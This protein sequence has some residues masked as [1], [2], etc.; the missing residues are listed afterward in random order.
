MAANQDVQ[1][2]LAALQGA[3]NTSSTPIAQNSLQTAAQQ[4]TSTPPMQAQL[5]QMQG[6]PAPAYSGVVPTPLQQNAYAPYPQPAA[7]GSID[8]NSIQ[9]VG[10]GSINF[11]DA[12]A[13]VQGFASARG[14]PPPSSTGKSRLPSSNHDAH[15]D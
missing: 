15:S 9:P 10:H 8:L 3:L 12:L 7:P 11:Q 2:I 13:K 5:P 6:M 4:P 1:A 14:I